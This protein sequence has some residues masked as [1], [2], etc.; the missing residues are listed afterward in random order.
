MMNEICSASFLRMD[1]GIKGECGSAS[2][3]FT[4]QD[5]S[6]AGMLNSFER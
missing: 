3:R 2:A 5:R 6:D 1:I 4:R